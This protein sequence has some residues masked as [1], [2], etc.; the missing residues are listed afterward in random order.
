VEG[1]LAAADGYDF[2]SCLVRVAVKGL[3][4]GK[5]MS[6]S[7]KAARDLLCVTKDD[8]AWLFLFG[9]PQAGL[10]AVMERLLPNG[11]SR[12]SAESHPE[13]ILVELEA[14]RGA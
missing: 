11:A 7:R 13:R 5:L 9:C 3:E 10:A 2:E 8:Q 12:W 1:L 4:A 6:Q 14:L